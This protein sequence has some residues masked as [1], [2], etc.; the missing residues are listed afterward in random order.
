MFLTSRTLLGFLC[1][2]FL[3]T[4]AAADEPLK[5]QIQL[6]KSVADEPVSGRL[7]VF[8]SK[9]RRTTHSPSWFDPQPFFAK[10]VTDFEPGTSLVIDD[11]ADCFPKKLSQLESGTYWVHAIMDH[12]F[13]APSPGNGVG[14][15][16]AEGMKITLSETSGT[17]N[18]VLDQ[19]VAEPVIEETEHIKIVTVDSQL[20]EDF[21][22]R[23]V[24]EK[25][26][27][28]LPASYEEE[29]ERRYPVFYEVAG[30]G[31]TIP[32]LALQ[33][34]HM[35]R[36]RRA[37]FEYIHV[38]L[39]GECKWGHHVYANSATNG[40]RGDALV[41]EMIPYI[42]DQFRTVAEP[43]A[44]YVGGHS[45]GGWSSLWLQVNY[46]DTFGGVWST[47]PDPI[48][49]RDFQQTNLYADPIESVYYFAD[50]SKKPLARQADQV[51][52]WY[53]QFA[54]MDDVLGRGGQL[55]SF[56]AVFSPLDSQGLPAQL[57]DRSTGKVSPEIA[58]A[59]KQYDIQRLLTENWETLA[60]KLAGKI[61]IRMGEQDTFYL[62]G[63]TRLLKESLQELGSDAQIDLVPGDHSTIM[64][65]KY[66][67]ERDQQ[68]QSIFLEHHPQEEALSV[69]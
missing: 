17:V 27:V 37:D 61:H 31:G 34:Q 11:T 16:Y 56:E 53:P 10:D 14:N 26:V 30:F 36:H 20:L 22:Q 51:M 65:R 60:P 29:P 21:H 15:Y 64:T 38:H 12:S 6:S 25:A 49:F 68:M 52:I 55:R 18:L 35:N 57:W 44:R 28:V 2:A 43:T 33:A 62:E 41:H 42:D 4:L 40:P 69:P 47:A 48:D 45:S 59:W 24:H 58:E 3:V 13:Y 67:K 63:A 7:Y 39:T 46:P 32:L 50:G 66:R 8:F 54:K 9:S 23:P 19:V 5:F 1:C